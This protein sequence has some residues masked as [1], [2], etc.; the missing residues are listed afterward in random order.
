MMTARQ[1][2]AP[3]KAAAD[4]SE[5]KT[6]IRGL[7]KAGVRRL[8]ARRVSHERGSAQGDADE[9]VT[10]KLGHDALRVEGKRLVPCSS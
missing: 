9:E 2:P 1:A 3:L 4:L 8:R 5:I 10:E 6:G 7:R